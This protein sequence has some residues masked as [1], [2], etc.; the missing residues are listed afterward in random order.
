MFIF[1]VTIT[2]TPIISETEIKAP[3]RAS[4]PR[5][6]NTAPNRRDILAVA[7]AASVGPTTGIS[8]EQKLEMQ[9]AKRAERAR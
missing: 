1:Q 9:R 8:P 7:T 2:A 6:M 4:A 3:Y 5:H